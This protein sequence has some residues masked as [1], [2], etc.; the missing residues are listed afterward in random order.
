MNSETLVLRLEKLGEA[1]KDV[2]EQNDS[3]ISQLKDDLV[4]SQTDVTD[5]N[6]QKK[7][8]LDRY[9][10]IEKER[11]ELKAKIKTMNSDL[12]EK[13]RVI[14]MALNKEEE[15]RSLKDSM[16]NI[17]QQDVLSNEEAGKIDGKTQPQEQKLYF[18]TDLQPKTLQL[19][20]QTGSPCK[21]S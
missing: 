13:E 7:E 20:P 16:L 11:E 21:T 8:L 9:K 14:I 15:V 5:A 12:V 2:F 10:V 19:W 4:A 3:Q 1:L 18:P 6:H 17:L